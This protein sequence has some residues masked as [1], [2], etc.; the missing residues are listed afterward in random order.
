MTRKK[1]TEKG[2]G[3]EDRGRREKTTLVVQ[4]YFENIMGR[5]NIIT[6]VWK[7]G[8]NFSAIVYL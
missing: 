5:T 3:E 4:D 1:G 8:A 7:E 2:Q 6:S